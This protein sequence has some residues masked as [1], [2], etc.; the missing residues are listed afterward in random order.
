VNEKRA[1]WDSHI[2]RAQKGT[3]E[4]I[5]LV[6]GISPTLDVA[7]TGTIVQFLDEECLVHLP[8]LSSDA[9]GER[10]L[11]VTRDDVD[12]RLAV[13]GWFGG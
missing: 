13:V 11:G 2:E 8:A 4:H 12:G 5:F 6:V 7:H 3:S 10:E 1:M 9:G